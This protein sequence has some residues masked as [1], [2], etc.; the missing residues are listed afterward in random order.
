MMAA[1]RTHRRDILDIPHALLLEWV[2]TRQLG[3]ASVAKAVLPNENGATTMHYDASSGQSG[4]RLFTQWLVVAT[5]ALAAACERAASVRGD[6]QSV[7]GEAIKIDDV[8]IRDVDSG[9]SVHY[10]TSTSIRD[11]GAQAAEMRKVWELVVK[12][13]LAESP[14]QRVVLF[15][16]DT[17]GQ[18]VSIEFTKSASG[19][20]TAGVPCS[21]RI[22][23]R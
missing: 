14:V 11:C 15:P 13:R 21:I 20:W 6:Q 5:I 1:A 9:I 12:T 3:F 19:E 16:E 10:R 23:A 18:S 8:N 2:I 17:S 22:P 4:R 7:P